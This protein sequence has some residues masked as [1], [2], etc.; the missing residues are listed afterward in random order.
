[1]RQFGRNIGN[2]GS[3]AIDQETGRLIDGEGHVI[4]MFT[5]KAML[6]RFPQFAALAY[7]KDEF[8]PKSIAP[9]MKHISRKK[10]W[11]TCKFVMP[12]GARIIRQGKSD[13][14]NF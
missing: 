3:G 13:P 5:M 7:L 11:K 6:N 14:Y 8:V 4:N 1:M 9:L 10:D 2:Y 12:I